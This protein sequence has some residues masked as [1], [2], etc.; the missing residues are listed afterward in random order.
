VSFPISVNAGET[1]PIVVD[2]TAGFNAV[3]S[4]IFLE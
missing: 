1:V 4:G 2:H 3:L